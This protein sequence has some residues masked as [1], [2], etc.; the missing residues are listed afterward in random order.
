MSTRLKI[1]NGT[2]S[3]LAPRLCDTCQSG[4]V[5]RGS[6]ESDEHVYCNFI[7]REVRTRVVECNVYVDRFQPSLWDLR[8]IAWVLEVDSKRQRIGFLRA[9]DWEKQHEAEELIPS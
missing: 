4:A 5:H 6:A 7:R 2:R 3:A 9:K 1:Q 8:Q